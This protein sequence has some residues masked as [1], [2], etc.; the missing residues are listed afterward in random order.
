MLTYTVP[1]AAARRAALAALDAGQGEGARPELGLTRRDVPV[2]LD[3]RRRSAP[4]TGRPAPRRSTSTADIADAT[5][6]YVERNQRRRVRDRVRRRASR[7]RRRGCG[8]SSGTTT[9]RRL[10]HRRRHRP[11]RVH[12]D[13]RQQRLHQPDGAAE[14]ARCRRRYA[15]DSPDVA[16]ALGVDAR[17]DR[18]TGATAADHMMMPYDTN[19]GV[20]PQAEEFTQHAVGTSRRH[21]PR[22]Y[23]LLLQLPILRPVP[24]AGRQA[25]RSVLAMYLRG[26]AFTPEREGPQLRLLRSR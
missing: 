17:G 15:S 18:P 3:Q 24:Q 13:R 19:S 14:P 4:A 11:R 26:D 23:P 6:R 10:P 22:H 16:A 8:R 21:R 1:E 5:A 12:R 25:G 20:H 2:A 9:S 7:W